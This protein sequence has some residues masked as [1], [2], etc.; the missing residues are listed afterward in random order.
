MLSVETVS[1]EWPAGSLGAALAMI[2]DHRRPTGW[3]PEYP[4]IALVALLQLAVA[5]LLCNARS[6]YAIAQWGRERLADDPGLLTDLGLPPGRSPCVATL[7]R[8]FKALDV[9]AF[10]QTLGG[11]LRTIGVRPSEPIAVDGKTLRGIHGETIPGVHLVA[12]YG[13]QS[14]AV[15]AQLRTAGK[16]HELAAAAAVLEAVPLAGRVVTG[17]GLLTQRDL[18]DQ[19]VAAGGDYLLPVKENQPAL[20]A[21][22]AEVFSPLGT[23]DAARDRGPAAA[24]L[25]RP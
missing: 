9:M 21:D 13:H 3:R 23:D 19:I 7:H 24:G 15:L 5:A 11:W 10:E 8:V 12:V 4:P 17:D 20:L 18:C 1:A 2:P 14:E 25:V 16:G 6:L 22:L